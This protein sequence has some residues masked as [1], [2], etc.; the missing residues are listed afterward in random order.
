MPVSGPPDYSRAGVTVAESASLRSQRLDS[1]AP[2]PSGKP[3]AT[4]P[5][6]TL[7]AWLD[8][9]IEKP[10]SID[11]IHGDDV[12]AGLASAPGRAGFLVPV[13]DK[14]ALFRT[15]LVEGA[16]PLGSRFLSREAPAP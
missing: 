3:P 2:A 12:V 11:Y 16:L 6:G 15:V 1:K 7:Q 14:H 9:V 10:E 13:M 5:V 8:D 4:L